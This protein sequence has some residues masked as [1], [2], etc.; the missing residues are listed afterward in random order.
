MEKDENN[1]AKGFRKFF[2]IVT[3]IFTLF[4]MRWFGLTPSIPFLLLGI[5]WLLLHIV[6]ALALKVSN[7]KNVVGISLFYFATIFMANALGIL[8]FNPRIVDAGIYNGA[9]HFLVASP[10]YDAAYSIDDIFITKWHDFLQFESQKINPYSNIRFFYDPTLKMVNVVKYDEIDDEEWLVYTDSNPPKYYDH[11][12]DF[13][14]YRFYNS[15]DCISWT[16]GR[17]DPIYSH[18]IYQCNIDNTGCTTLP[19]QYIGKETYASFEV[20]GASQEL[21]FYVWPDDGDIILVYSYG[22]HPRCHVEGCEVL[23]P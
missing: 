2:N 14:D 21:E 17:C 7:D 8:F 13:M 12:A 11:S 15:L 4:Y 19:F 20:N 6:T 23:Q 3:I 5:V 10:N 1:Y 18:V 9:I 16:K 22:D